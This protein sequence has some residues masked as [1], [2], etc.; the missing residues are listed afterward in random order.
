ML[1]YTDAKQLGLI[2]LTLKTKTVND[3]INIQ[4]INLRSMTTESKTVE[5]VV[6]VS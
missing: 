3:T 2:F 4:N 5:T 1:K 6:Q